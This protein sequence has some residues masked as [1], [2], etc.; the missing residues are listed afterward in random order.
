MGIESPKY[1]QSIVDRKIPNP[2][3]V[4][5]SL[6]MKTIVNPSTNVHEI[7]AL[8]GLIHT[9]VAYIAYC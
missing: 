6:S 1:V 3:M 7:V 9:K 2:P 5:L 4:T 8:A